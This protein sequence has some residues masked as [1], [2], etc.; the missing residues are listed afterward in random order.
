MLGPLWTTF[1][2]LGW[3][4]AGFGR[5]WASLGVNLGA[6][7]AAWSPWAPIF[8]SE[9]DFSL[10]V[11]RFEP[12]NWIKIVKLGLASFNLFGV[13]ACFPSLNPKFQS[14]YVNLTMS[15]GSPPWMRRSP[16]SGL[17][18]RGSPPPACE[19]GPEVIVLFIY[20]LSKGQRGQRG[21][22]RSK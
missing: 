10:I 1:G 7:G 2:V 16:R 6:L 15:I 3:L 19:I 5:L 8:V 21:D 9:I 4:W 22:R 18:A 20:T 11:G 12:P 13:E 17:N 14:Q